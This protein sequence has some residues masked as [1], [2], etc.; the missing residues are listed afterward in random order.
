M[1]AVFWVLTLV[2]VAFILRWTRAIC[3]IYIG[4]AQDKILKQANTPKKFHFAQG[5]DY[6]RRNF[7]EERKKFD[8]AVREE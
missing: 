1:E 3:M 8:E 6:G 5:Y 7:L 2:N 4:K